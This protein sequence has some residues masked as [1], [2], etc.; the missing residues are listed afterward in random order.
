MSARRVNIQTD[1]WNTEPIVIPTNLNNKMFR[2]VLTWVIKEEIHGF[3]L[4]EGDVCVSIEWGAK[5]KICTV[6]EFNKQHL[7]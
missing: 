4:E 3:D 2:Q 5:H 6:E 1:I 7:L